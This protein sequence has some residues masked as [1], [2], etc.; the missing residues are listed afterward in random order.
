MKKPKLS[1]WQIWN[2]S[3]GFLGI[4]FGWALQL[5]NGSRIFQG[6]GANPSEIPILWIAAPVTGLLVQ[7]IIGHMS[8]NTW[9][10]IGRRKPYFLVGA[11]LA[12]IGLCFMPF[13]P[14]LWVAAGVL[15]ILDASINISME[16][17]RAFVGDML[18][19]EQRTRG[20]AM[21]SF[22]IGVG[23]VTA[24]L[25]PF[26]LTN[27]FDL[28]N[29]APEGEIAPSIKVS[30]VL[31]GIMFLLCVLWTVFRTKEYTPKEIEAFQETE[32]K[33][34]EGEIIHSEFIKPGFFFKNGPIWIATGLTLLYL[35]IKFTHHQEPIILAV[36]LIIFGLI[37]LLVG[38]LSKN[39]SHESGLVEV[40]N[41]LFKMPKTMKQLAWVQFFSWFGLFSMFIYMTPAVT[42]HVYGTTDVSSEAYG[43]GADWV[44]VLFA[45]YNAVA[46]GVAFLLS[47]LSKRIGR[48]RVHQIALILGGLGLISIYF[49]SDPDLLIISMIGIGVAWASILSIPYAILTG[50]LP[51]RKF[52][53]YMG[54][55]NFFI[56]I[57]EITASSIYGFLFEEWFNEQSVFVLITGGV[58]FVIAALMVFLVEDKKESQSE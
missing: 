15:W 53:I 6:L 43:D 35:I 28:E 40:I 18:P 26:I 10:S 34:T 55:F 17:F 54:I 49:I 56:V 23:S 52:G 46:A 39:E 19:E 13:S 25:L 29:K 48:K 50:S 30:F 11:I 27:L 1:F 31:G 32:E 38:F 12:S 51:I 41:D 58:S 4:Q 36:G 8:D 7:P 37:Q 44:S 42:S 22:F 16:P 9:N 57:P 20:F 21:Q 5:A 14:A 33:Q 24:S 2:M 3:F 47:P 45:V